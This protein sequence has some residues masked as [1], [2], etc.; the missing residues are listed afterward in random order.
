MSNI[1]Q[2]TKKIKK[3]YYSL[4]CKYY[5]QIKSLKQINNENIN[6]EQIHITNNW[7]DWMIKMNNS[8]EEKQN[9]EILKID[10]K[11]Y[12]FNDHIKELISKDIIE[13]ECLICYKNW[14]PNILPYFQK[15][16]GKALCKSCRN[17]LNINF[18][19]CPFCRRKIYA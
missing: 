7:D 12:M 14:K 6:N 4:K 10:A 8:I 11:I 13:E 15:C 9:N 5:K 16:C 17:K 19:I 3:E 1:S 2:R 18:I